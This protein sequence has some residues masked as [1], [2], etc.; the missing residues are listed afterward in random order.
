MTPEKLL[1]LES[2][3][4]EFKET[5]LL[6]LPACTEHLENAQKVVQEITRIQFNEV[7]LLNA[8]KNLVL[9]G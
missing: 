2:L 8:K 1:V 4:E 9:R 5:Y 7:A 6:Q 3:L